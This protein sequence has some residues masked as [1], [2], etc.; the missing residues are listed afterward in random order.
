MTIEQY[1][2]KDCEYV[3]HDLIARDQRTLVHDLNKSEF[4][5]L[6]GATHV[7][8][9]G[10]LEYLNDP[11]GFWIWLAKSGA[12]VILSYAPIHPSFSIERRRSMGWFND[13]S[14]QEI[15]TMAEKAGFALVAEEPIPPLTRTYSCSILGPLDQASFRSDSLQKASDALSQSRA[16]FT[17]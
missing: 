9:L 1:L 10:V 16:E 2:P 4:P 15:V 12:R 17:V 8:V 13:F 6:N 5:S 11:E 3:P 7:T 14:K